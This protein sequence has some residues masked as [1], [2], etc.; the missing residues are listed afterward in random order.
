MTEAT[1]TTT[2]TA[3]KP[4]A[5]RKT[6]AKPKPAVKRKPATKRAPAKKPAPTL[7]TTAQ[8]SG[9]NVFLAGLGVYG[10]AYDQAQ[11]QLSGLQKEVAQRRKKADKIYKEL[12]K[13]GAK[14]EKDAKV[15]IKEI[16]LP[17][18][19]LDT[20]TDRKKLQAQLKKAKA[21]LTDLK[22]SIGIKSAA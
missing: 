10:K 21:R 15:A 1:G 2:T 8:E 4:K 5:T 16:D 11:E 3:T 17:K 20:L 19:E 9:R 22:G 13:R 12:V 6:A 7:V 18:L 14:V